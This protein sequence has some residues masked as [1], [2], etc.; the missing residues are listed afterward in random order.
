MRLPRLFLAA[1]FLISSSLLGQHSSSG[2]SSGS[3]SS[4]S[5][6]GGSHSSSSGGSSYSGGS[7]GGGS[8][9]S[10]G[11]FGGSSHS[12]GASQGWAG[13]HSSGS[14]HGSGSGHVSGGTSVSNRSA[15]HRSSSN[16]LSSS[17]IAKESS[18]SKIAPIRQP[19]SGASERAAVAQKRGFFTFLRHP[20]RKPQPKVVQAKAGLYLPR[21]IC[22]KGR[23]APG[24]P[25][26]QVSKGGAC[27]SP[28]I[29]LCGRGQ[30][31]AACSNRCPIGQ[32]WNGGSC[33]YS[34]RFLDN[35]I[36]LRMA[37]NRQA[38]RVQAAESIRQSACSNGPAQECSSATSTWQSEESLRE[39]L[40]RGYEQCR[41]HSIP[42]Y[43]AQYGL[44]QFDPMLWFNSLEFNA[45]F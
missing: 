5:S 18:S 20:F 9:S 6:G 24:C 10:G 2:G 44:R 7:S 19:K 40:L 15:A 41:L 34:A 8:H 30:W 26:G 4:G 1:I 35:C 11:S 27:T 22:L 14:S 39:K 3:S 45:V 42:E 13:G 38:Q 43:S 12:A 16:L 33:G 37:L 28:V 31:N 36:G 21:P 32:V 25:T 29:P 23:C 17:R